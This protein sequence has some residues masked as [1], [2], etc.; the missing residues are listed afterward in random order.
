[1]KAQIAVQEVG[2]KIRRLVEELSRFCR[3]VGGRVKTRDT[4]NAFVFSCIFDR[5][6]LVMFDIQSWRDDIFVG[7]D[8]NIYRF[9]DTPRE[10]EFL[11]GSVAIMPEGPVA[12]TRGAVKGLLTPTK[13]NVHAEIIA[14]SFSIILHKD[15]K[16]MEIHTPTT[17]Y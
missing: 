3:N 12:T 14:D 2:G 8:E 15:Y 11:F 10:R 17:L 9:E 7:V 6:R 5:E 4:L 13:G 1:M 16:K